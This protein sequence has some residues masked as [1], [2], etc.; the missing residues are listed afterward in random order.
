M[1]SKL[2]YG[3]IPY[4]LDGSVDALLAALLGFPSGEEA[5]ARALPMGACRCLPSSLSSSYAAGPRLH[6][7]LEP[8][9]RRGRGGQLSGC[10]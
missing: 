4:P 2:Y 8:F 1:I 3:P 7:R 9:Y 5:K 6:D 10:P